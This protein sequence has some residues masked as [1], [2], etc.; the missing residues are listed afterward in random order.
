MNQFT[1]S[2]L[3]SSGFTGVQVWNESVA[4][5]FKNTSTKE[6]FLY[7]KIGDDE[8]KSVSYMQAFWQLGMSCAAQ[9]LP[10]GKPGNEAISQVKSLF[11]TCQ[12]YNRLFPF[13]L[14]PNWQRT[15]SFPLISLM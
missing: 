9:L 2:G 15:G 12:V 1:K 4:D 8:C 10:S 11:I 3:K 13:Q 7:V 6:S 14:S 5:I